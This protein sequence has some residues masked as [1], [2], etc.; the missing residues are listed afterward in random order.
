MLDWNSIGLTQIGIV[1]SPARET[2]AMCI[3]HEGEEKRVTTETLV[4]I[5]N[6]NWNKILA[7]CRRGTGANDALKTDY[8][9]PGIATP[10]GGRTPAPLRNFTG[11]TWL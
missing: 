9:N 5:D 4:L 2:E 3:L 8:Y 11:L 1:A 6:R 10:S 7:V